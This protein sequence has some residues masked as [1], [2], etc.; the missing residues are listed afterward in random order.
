MISFESNLDGE[1][2]YFTKPATMIWF[3]IWVLSKYNICLAHDST[4]CDLHLD[5]DLQILILEM[6]NRITS[7]ATFNNDDDDGDDKIK[8]GKFMSAQN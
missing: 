7:G 6:P 4:V 1:Y 3:L 2:N 8:I 5:Y